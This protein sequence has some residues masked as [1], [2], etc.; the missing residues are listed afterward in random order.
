MSPDL[1]DSK[2]V[3]E[4]EV[5]RGEDRVGTLTRT[6]AGARFLYDPEYA[7]ANSEH[8]H[9]AIAFKMPVRVEPFD[10]RGINLHPFFAGL[11]P[12]GLRLNSLVR[13]VKT[14]EDDL[15]SLLAAAGTS[16]VGDVWVRSPLAEE[17][18]ASPLVDSRKL[19]NLSFEEVLEASLVGGKSRDSRSISGVQPKV[20]AAMIS[21]PLR[22]RSKQR[23]YILKLTPKSHA[24][25]AE[26]EFFF[27]QLARSLRLP[28]AKADLV[29]DK[30][31]N[32]G[33]LVER[34]DR[35]PLEPGKAG[36][37]VR[38]HQEDACQ[39]LN[40]YPSEKYRISLRQISDAL[41]LCS[42]P[43]IERYRLIQL[44][45][46]SY[47]IGNGDLH[48]KNV[49][50]QTVGKKIALTPIYDLLSTHPYGDDS[51]ALKM[52]GRDKKLKRSEFVAFGARIGVSKIAT[53]KMLDSIVVAVA[54]S[55]PRLGEIGM[56]QR[57]TKQ[58]DRVM[59]VR[60]TEL[61]N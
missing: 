50:V 55:L 38:L 35:V 56:D 8:K 47:A 48:G 9:G 52:D 32:S 44:Y 53:E 1:Q 16:T 34:F 14:S 4:L 28:T 54:R 20:S 2:E 42:A 6:K 41:E 12:E 25:L 49:S 26:N 39:L 30:Y 7:A 17:G 22:T 40:R 36:P 19:A 59:R 29:H 31:G 21:I 43:T 60:M 27:M 5:L 58:L 33:L 51:M 11:L 18:E 13:E 45:A 24:R 10:V 3:L 15:F 23:E 61:A 37:P 46:L 57:K